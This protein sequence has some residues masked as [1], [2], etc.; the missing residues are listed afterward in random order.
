MPDDT[1]SASSLGPLGL[2]VG[3]NKSVLDLD[4]T[5]NSNY[6]DI[7]TKLWVVYQRNKEF[8]TYL[9]QRIQFVGKYDIDP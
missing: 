8:P 2:S 5:I 4:K 3:E 7:W 6:Y 9:S 1:R